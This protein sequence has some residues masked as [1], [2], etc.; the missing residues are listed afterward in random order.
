MDTLT[1]VAIV[2]EIMKSLGIKLDGNYQDKS[3]H[4]YIKH[5]LLHNH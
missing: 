1:N 4:N 3:H 2:S 5:I